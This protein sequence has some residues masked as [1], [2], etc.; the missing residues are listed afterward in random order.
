MD[1]KKGKPSITLGLIIKIMMIAKLLIS[2]LQ[3]FL[4]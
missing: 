2:I 1:N 3:E 4:K